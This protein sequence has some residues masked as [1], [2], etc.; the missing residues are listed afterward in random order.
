MNI[1][2]VSWNTSDSF[3]FSGD[4]ATERT[5]SID[6]PI[7]DYAEYSAFA[8]VK[9]EMYIFGGERDTHKLKL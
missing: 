5:I 3:I 7:Y 2:F 1:I 8:V 6:S 9:D 4:G